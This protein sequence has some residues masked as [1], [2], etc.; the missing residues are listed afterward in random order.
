MKA[1][2][3]H[4]CVQALKTIKQYESMLDL[5]LQISSEQSFGRTESNFQVRLWKLEQMLSRA[6]RM[7]RILLGSQDSKLSADLT[8]ARR[9]NG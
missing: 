5:V 7:E 2:W 4:S 3:E 1:D 6:I 9:Y 8:Q